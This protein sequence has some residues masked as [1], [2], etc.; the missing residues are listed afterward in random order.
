VNGGVLQRVILDVG[1]L[2]IGLR[3]ANSFD[4]EPMQD[5]FGT[6]GMIQLPFDST[7]RS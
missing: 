3:N 2:K 7:G 6:I 1:S 5:L 4:K